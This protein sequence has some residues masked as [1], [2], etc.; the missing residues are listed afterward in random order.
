M[1]Q[2]RTRALVGECISRAQVEAAR[3]ATL[4]DIANA[5]MVC[6]YERAATLVL[7]RARAREPVPFEA[8]ACVL[9]G[10][11]LPSI[12]LALISI[13]PD[14]ERLLELVEDRRFPHS[15]EACELEAMAVY[16]A[17]RAGADLERVIPELRRLSARP[18]S[19]ESYALLATIAAS[20]DDP[21]VVAATK[22]IA[23]FAKEYAKQVAADDRV[24]AAPIDALVASLPAEVET[25]RVAGFTVRSQKQAGR[26]DPCPCGSGLK[27][28][29]CCADKPERRDVTPSPVP[30]L[31]WEQFI[32]GEGM[33]PA[34]VQDLALRD[35]VRIELGKLD[36]QVLTAVLRRF[37]LAHEWDHAER[38]VDEA[39]RRGTLG[40]DLRDELAVYLLEA[41]D[42]HRARHHVA[43]L[44]VALGK[45]FQLEL[46]IADGP[47]TAWPALVRAARDA[48]TDKLAAIDLAYALLRAAP[49]VGILA[50]RACIG[51]L[52]FDD[53]DLLLELVE[54]A[55][56]RLNV[57]PEDPAWDVLEML[58]A[59]GK[60]KTA[61]DGA[62]LQQAVA[63]SSARIAELERKLAT[64]HSELDRERTRPA[65]ELMRVPEQKGALDDR[66]RELE[67]LIREGNAERRE[68]RKQLEAAASE[69]ASTRREGPRARRV[70]V[71][72]A[73]DDVGDAVEAG[74]RGIAIPRFERRALDALAGVPGNVAAEAMRTIGTLAAGDGYA[75]RGAKQAK[76]MTRPVL[77]ARV[78]IHHRLLFRVEDGSLEVLDLITREQ[79]LTTLKRLRN[80]R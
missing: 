48:A 27:F 18:M 44:P 37:L 63:D 41:G 75:W 33:K 76:D 47:E 73:D 25:T 62:K 10:I 12:A 58:S 53:P 69:E 11:E 6:D 21:N 74:A 7:G 3:G 19:V 28:K 78:G 39:A 8:I 71:E 49:S 38:I 72:E 68:L 36:D 42:I 20:I 50:A 64:V 24:L 4:D 35:L 34:H 9:P 26:N 32:T 65:A 67:S 5:C 80:A 45:L 46:A 22:P 29:K 17:W 43:H 54:D 2:E 31:S 23:S 61:D 52:Q 55:R 1:Q 60:P 70:T 56:D 51:S 59:H 40:D 30:G 57:P 13:S 77:M 15:K 79:L 16:A 14:R 66:V